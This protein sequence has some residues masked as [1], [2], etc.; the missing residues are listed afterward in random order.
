MGDFLTMRDGDGRLL[1]KVSRSENR[2]YKIKLKVG[3]PHYLQT[4]F[5]EEA[6]LCHTRL[7]HINFGTVNLMHKLYKGHKS[8]ASKIIKGFKTSIEKRTSKEVKTFHTDR[9]GEFRST[10][11]NRFYN[12]EWISCMCDGS[13]CTSTKSYSRTET[14]DST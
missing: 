1:M 12:E 8:D 3:T 4:R 9:G 2:L 10:E 11:L 5:N 7:G 13:L 14:S 6:W